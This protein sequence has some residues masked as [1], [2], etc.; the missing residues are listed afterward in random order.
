[1]QKA[2]RMLTDIRHEQMGIGDIAGACGFTDAAY[3]TRRF[4]MRFGM[5]P[6]AFRGASV[7]HEGMEI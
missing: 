7:S 2:R 4:R 5:S 6:T 1:L 3:F